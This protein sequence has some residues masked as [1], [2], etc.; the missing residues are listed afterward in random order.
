M[1]MPVSSLSPL[2]FQGRRNRSADK[3]NANASKRARYFRDEYSAVC[4]DRSRR[5][6][7]RERRRLNVLEVELRETGPHY[8][9]MDF[10][11]QLYGRDVVGLR[12]AEMA[13]RLRSPLGR[14]VRSENPDPAAIREA[15][16]GASQAE[17]D[18]VFRAAP[19]HASPGFWAMVDAM[20]ASQRGVSAG[21]LRDTYQDTVDHGLSLIQ[22][23][24]D[25][26]LP[27]RSGRVDESTRRKQVQ[28][29]LESRFAQ[30]LDISRVLS[31]HL[32]MREWRY[33]EGEKNAATRYLGSHFQ[34]K[35]RDH[36][37]R[38]IPVLKNE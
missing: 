16:Q 1:S 17:L 25:P 12:I 29:P 21:T 31:D 20:K 23:H 13:H 11:R 33:R 27:Q 28:D 38:V 18:E 7:R 26:E 5:L 2:T 22:M 9:H 19:H 8:P 37:A 10:E 6:T 34:V 30:I 3:P 36:K 24:Q 4:P 15:L 14:A 35:P 32:N